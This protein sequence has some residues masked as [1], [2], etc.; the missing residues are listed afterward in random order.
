[1]EGLTL[2]ALFDTPPSTVDQL[3]DRLNRIAGDLGLAFGKRRKTFNSRLAQELGKW[4]QDRGRGDAF[5]QAAFQAYFA[6]GMNL[7]RLPVLLELAEMAQLPRAAA[8]QVI[9]E[10][11]YRDAIDRDWQKSAEKQVTAVPTFICADRR[12]VGAQ[13]YQAL[14]QLV[15]GGPL[16]EGP[17]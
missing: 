13:T 5:H 2:E 8:R 7:A 14:K 3:N 1:M 9:E 17:A 6:R 11:R 4:A 12:L 10:R 15:T 16:A